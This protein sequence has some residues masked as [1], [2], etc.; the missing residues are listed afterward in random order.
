MPRH[1]MQV[2][3]T[4]QQNAAVLLAMER[5]QSAYQDRAAVWAVDASRGHIAM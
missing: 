2:H 4:I 1:M 5:A 3:E